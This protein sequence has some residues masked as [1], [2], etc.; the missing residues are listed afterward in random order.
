MGVFFQERKT[1]VGY[2]LRECKCRAGGGPPGSANRKPCVESTEEACRPPC[3]PILHAL[4]PALLVLEKRPPWPTRVAIQPKCYEIGKRNSDALHECRVSEV[5][6]H[7]DSRIKCGINSGRDLVSSGNARFL[8]PF[9]MTSLLTEFVR[10][11]TSR[12]LKKSLLAGCSKMPRCKLCRFNPAIRGG[13][14]TWGPTLRW[15][16]RGP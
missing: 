12:L 9:E 16:V 5:T 1:G 11:D 13:A 10:R 6:C 8:T 4:S 2:G 15:G 14:R 3:P 7:L